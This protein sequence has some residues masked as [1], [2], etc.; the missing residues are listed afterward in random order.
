MKIPKK[1]QDRVE[2]FVKYEEGEEFCST[3]YEIW[4]KEG[5]TLEDSS[6]H[7]C[8]TYQEALQVMREAEKE[9]IV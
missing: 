5:W 9:V 6:V 2:S 4:L 7:Y 1:Y 8:E 3:T